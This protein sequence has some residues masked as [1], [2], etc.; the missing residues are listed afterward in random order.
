MFLLIVFI[1][2]YDRNKSKNEVNF[3]KQMS[4]LFNKNKNADL[5][6]DFMDSTRKYHTNNTNS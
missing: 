1:L 2:F 3:Y 5:Q 6:L 4:L